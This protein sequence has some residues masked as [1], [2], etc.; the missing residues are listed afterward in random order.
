MIEKLTPATNSISPAA[1][2]MRRHRERKRK[3][4]HL[5]Q[6]LLRESEIG[7]LIDAGLL[8]ECS[9]NDWNAVTEA[10]HQLFDRIFSRN[11]RNVFRMW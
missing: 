6:V 11:P 8:D 10:V 7:A 1:E 3:G 9:R 4:L 5:V 2:R